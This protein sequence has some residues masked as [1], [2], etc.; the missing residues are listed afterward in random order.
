MRDIALV[1]IVFGSL[2]FILARPYIGILM[3]SWLGYMSPHRLAY[4]FAYDFP[5]AQ[6]VAITTILA[7]LF[8]R[9]KK[10]FPVNSLTIVWLIFL[11]WMCITTAFAIFPEVSLLQLIKVLKIQLVTL[12]TIVVMGSREKLNLLVWVI[13]LSLGFYGIK[14]GIFTI[15]TGGSYRVWGP[16]GSFISGNN[17]LALALLMAI[18]L[19]YYLRDISENIWV[20]QGLL[21]AM[22]LIAISVVGSQSRGAFL[23]G[24]TMASW[25]WFRRRKKLLPAVFL[26]LLGTGVLLFMPAEW[27]GR[28]ESIQNYQEDGSAMGRIN[29]WTAAIN[30]S[31]DRFPGGGF[32]GIN[33]SSVFAVYAKDPD[34]YHDSHSIYFEVLGDHGMPGLLLFLLLG[35]VA[36]KSCGLLIKQTLEHKELVWLNSLARMVQVSLIAYAAGGA[37]LG[38][39]YF[40]LYYHL[41]A[42]ILIGRGIAE[43]YLQEQIPSTGLAGEKLTSRSG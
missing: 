21:I 12:L 28:M 22:V 29:A 40:D 7:F 9:E 5:F 35:I 11:A 16:G 8:N 14:G 19:G 17:E 27:H 25:L 24:I 30:I 23:A 15:L 41:I 4:G 13:F 3:W 20:R 37:F 31:K 36:L 43:K 42:I 2:P 39:A 34:D 33:V 26:A 32:N 6:I 18:P 1:I 10:Y 38:L